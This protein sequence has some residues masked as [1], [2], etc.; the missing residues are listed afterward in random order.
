MFGWLGDLLGR[1]RTYTISVLIFGLS[2]VA[3]GLA[4]TYLAFLLTRIGAGVGMGALFGLSFSMFAECWKTRKRNLMGGSIQAMYFTAEI[5]TEGV[6]YFS[7]TMFGHGTGWRAGYV[8]IGAVT[9]LIAILAG[10]FLPESRQWLT[11]QAALRSGELPPELRR[12]KV[13]MV[14]LFRRRYAFGT[15]LFVVVATSMF[16]TTNSKIAYLS[17]FLIK[18]ERVPLGTASVIVFLC[19]L[20]TAITYPL[21]GA[22]SDVIRRKWAFF[23]CCAVGVLGFGWFL[24]LVLTGAAHVSGDRFWTTRRSG[25]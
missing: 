2:A 21:G 3:G 7:I 11:Y 5:V 13:P 10:F 17:T 16:L 1:R 14:D 8:V 15:V 6:I 19:L 12:N 24:T 20:C 25:R 18:V 4:P 9:V 22:L 23:C